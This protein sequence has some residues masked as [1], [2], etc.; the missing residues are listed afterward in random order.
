MDDDATGNPALHD[1][2]GQPKQ[3]EGASL[4][5]LSEPYR[6]PALELAASSPLRRL[7]FRILPN[8][9]IYV[10]RVLVLNHFAKPP[11]Q[12]GG[13]RHVDLFSRLNEW[14]PRIVAANRNNLSDERQRPTLDAPIVY[15]P[16]IGGRSTPAR[17]LGWIVYT[18]GALWVGC[19]GRRPHVVYGSSPHL[20]AALAGLGVSRWW[21][22]PFV[23]E[24]RDIWPRILH[25]L[26]GMSPHSL[27]YRLLRRLEGFLYRR[28]DH[29]VHLAAGNREYLI[30][31]GVPPER[32]TF[33]PNSVAPTRARLTREQARHHLGVS[34]TVAA[35]TGAH[36]TANGLDLLLD[37]AGALHDSHSDLTI[38]MVGDGSEKP[39][40][41]ARAQREQLDNVRFLDPVPK[42]DLPD[43]LAA[44]DLGVH[45]LADV[46]LFRHGVS[47]NKVMD[48]LAAG[49]PVV[50]NSPGE[51][52][53]VV[54]A[55]AAGWICQPSKLTAGLTQ[56]LHAGAD[57]RTRRG[58]CG[59]KYVEQ[60]R[61][62]NLMAAELQR[63]LNDVVGSKTE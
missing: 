22:V 20:F 14:D 32:L 42:Q 61:N 58:M 21:R 49:L 27:L 47:P 41:E 45:V 24:I 54:E 55:A 3:E 1:D 51:V 23:L 9:G 7:T 48:Y 8:R 28:A 57:E 38:L 31:E 37:A 35:Y 62:P 5:L 11:G 13:N 12:P 25:E 50:T 4:A 60:Q 2:R 40:L 17:L 36:G 18:V 19:V 6:I 26:G 29:L 59:L 16:G 56:A 52:G 34:G 10:R 15:V 30:E 44:C 39:R 43:I 53:D 33:I 63:V 46:D